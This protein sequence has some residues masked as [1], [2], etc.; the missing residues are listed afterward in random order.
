MGSLL[1]RE[2]GGGTSLGRA[3]S[4]GGYHRGPVVARGCSQTAGPKGIRSGEDSGF[5]AGPRRGPRRNLRNLTTEIPGWFVG[6]PGGG[7]R[8][9]QGPTVWADHCILPRRKRRDLATVFP[10]FRAVHRGRER[11][12]GQVLTTKGSSC[13]RRGGPRKRPPRN[14]QDMATGSPDALSGLREEPPELDHTWLQNLRLFFWALASGPAQVDWVRKR[15]RG[16][17]GRANAGHR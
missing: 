2:S 5:S 6:S 4:V 8:D 1:P 10:D 3:T 13:L 17:F 14:R 12:R 15:I 9:G 11:R 16:I 7:A